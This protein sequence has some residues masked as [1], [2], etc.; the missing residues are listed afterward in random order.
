LSLEPLS[1]IIISS[2][3]ESAAR[4][5]SIL[6]SSLEQIIKAEILLTD[7]ARSH[8]IAILSGIVTNEPLSREGATKP[9]NTAHQ[10]KKCATV[11]RGIF[12]G[13]SYS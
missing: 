9:A 4:H 5:L 11:K 3:K 10:S 2:Q 8:K 1:I 6:S 7:M 12:F 13:M